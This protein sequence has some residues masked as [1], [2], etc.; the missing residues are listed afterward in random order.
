MGQDN[1]FHHS[2]ANWKP[3][4]KSSGT[5][6]FQNHTYQ[7]IRAA[8]TDGAE[9]HPWSFTAQKKIEKVQS[10]E[11][12]YVWK[13]TSCASAHKG[14]KLCCEKK[15]STGFDLSTLSR[16]QRESALATLMRI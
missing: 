8:A 7:L 10:V 9:G 4:S 11:G 5:I 1:F 14:R 12:G 15:A 16:E 6:G 13:T 3:V 2:F